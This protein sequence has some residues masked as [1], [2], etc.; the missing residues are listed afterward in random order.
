MRYSNYLWVEVEAVVPDHLTLLGVI[1]SF[2]EGV[3]DVKRWYLSEM[4]SGKKC[5]ISSQ[6]GHNVSKFI[7][8]VHSNIEGIKITNVE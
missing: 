4:P 1:K 7:E 8:H 2:E 6:W 5:Y 3:K